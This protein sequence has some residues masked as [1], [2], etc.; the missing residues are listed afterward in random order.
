MSASVPVVVSGAKIQRQESLT[1]DRDK[2]K[3][4]LRGKMIPF[5][6]ESVIAPNTAAGMGVSTTLPEAFSLTVFSIRLAYLG[7]IHGCRSCVHEENSSAV[8][9]AAIW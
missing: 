2:E 6:P 5:V 7:V 3:V 1:G 8:R 9:T 4:A